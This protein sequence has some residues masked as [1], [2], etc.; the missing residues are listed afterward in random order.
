MIRPLFRVHAPSVSAL[1]R[2]CRC[3]FL[4]AAIKK[5]WFNFEKN[6]GKNVRVSI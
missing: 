1:W 4:P 5:Y 2:G 3:P 6:F